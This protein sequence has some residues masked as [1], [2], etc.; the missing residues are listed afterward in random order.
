MALRSCA[1]IKQLI[2]CLLCLALV[3]PAPAKAQGGVGII[4]D[5][6]IELLLADYARPV[7]QAAGLGGRGINVTLLSDKGFNAFVADGQRIFITVG[8]LMQAETPNEIIG[9]VAHE[10]G[11]IAGGHLARLRE[12]LAT[13]QTL[14]IV[15]FLLGIGAV[16]AGAAGGRGSNIGDAAPGLILG[17][18]EAIKRSFLAYQRS[19]EQA[20]D[21]SAITYLNKTGQSAKG[22]L[23][24]F[25]RFHEEL[26]F[27]ANAIDRYT[28]SH[29]MPKERI[30]ALEELAKS[31]PHFDKKDPPALQARHDLARAKVIGYMERAEVVN[32]RYPL[33]NTSMP[34]RYARAISAH[35]NARL[36]DALR[37]MDA[38]LSQQPQN[39]YFL[40]LK[41]QILLES[42]RGPESLPYLKASAQRFPGSSLIRGLYG[43]ALLST[44]NPKHIEEAIRELKVA[45][46]RDATNADAFRHLSR[47]YGRKGDVARAELA[48]AESY[49]LE[50]DVKS[51]REQAARARKKLPEGSLEWQRA[52]D[53]VNRKVDKP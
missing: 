25:R 23:I 3:M 36:A 52:D 8:A 48:A 39:P 53:L 31:S 38:L 16:A 49:W 17:P 1:P 47:A 15:G 22:M 40:E 20:A 33:T 2:S 51:G 10:A 24:T 12:Q 26:G 43:Q 29:P 21:R 4:R 44:E 6:E 19:E 28:V 14:S 50:G 27:L 5:A 35:R 30:A 32:R 11:H 34:A 13:A 18:Q 37:E 7:L 45:V 46:G 9:V 41:G 42:G